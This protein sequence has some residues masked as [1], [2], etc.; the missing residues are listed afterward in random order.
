MYFDDL[1][2]VSHNL[3]C[4]NIRVFV[5]NQESGICGEGQ[6]VCSGTAECIA[7][8]RVCDGTYDCWLREDEDDCH[9]NTLYC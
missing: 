8:V 3:I 4:V 2:L 9:G 6:F 5:Y 7:A 1:I